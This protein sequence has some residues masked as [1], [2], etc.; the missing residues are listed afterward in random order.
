[1][2][3]LLIEL[4]DED[5]AVQLHA[6]EWVGALSRDDLMCLSLLLHH[7]LVTR[8][9]INLTEAAK[10]IGEMIQRSDPT[11]REWRATY[12]CNDNSFPDSLQG[13]YQRSVVWQNEDLNR[14]V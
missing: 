4:L 1:M 14:H 13:K 6:E 11:V 2:I 12:L 7:L 3:L 9:H 5:A 10:L 8:M